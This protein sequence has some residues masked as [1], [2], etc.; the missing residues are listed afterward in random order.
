MF[1][2]CGGIPKGD[3]RVERKRDKRL[4]DEDAERKCR[5]EVKRLYGLK[6]GIPGCKEPGTEQH[7]IQYRSRARKL[8]YEPTNRVPLCS[9]HHQLEHAGKITIHPRTA[10]GELVVTGDRKYLEFRL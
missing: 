8:K 4:T 9:A 1:K 7:H 10:S 2:D 3:L 6:C 5:A